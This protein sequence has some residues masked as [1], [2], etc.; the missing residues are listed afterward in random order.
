M[1]RFGGRTLPPWL[2]RGS[3]RWYHDLMTPK[4]TILEKV[5]ELSPEDQDK[6]FADASA[7]AD[8]LFARL[9]TIEPHPFQPAGV[10]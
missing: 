2:D 1:L 4:E 5:K 7:A 6:V 3:G 9:E 8:L 10:P